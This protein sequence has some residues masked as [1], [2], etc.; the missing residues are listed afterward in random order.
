MV[1][2]NSL[3]G[4]LH[5][6]ILLARRHCP[7]PPVLTRTN[8]DSSMHALHAAVYENTLLDEVAFDC[9]WMPHYMHNSWIACITHVRA[10][11]SITHVMRH[12]SLGCRITCITLLLLTLLAC[13]ITHRESSTFYN[14]TCM[15]H[16]SP[17]IESRVPFTVTACTTLPFPLN[18]S[19]HPS[20]EIV[21]TLSPP[22]PP[23][24]TQKHANSGVKKGICTGGARLSF[25]SPTPSTTPPPRKKIIMT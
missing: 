19:L 13:R 3:L 17:R 24:N 21:A 25:S 15:P 16:Y 4:K 10:A 12:V 11:H 14:S 9:I 23:L 20:K 6:L 8:R 1:R 18:L 22:L 5:G 7:A 2:S